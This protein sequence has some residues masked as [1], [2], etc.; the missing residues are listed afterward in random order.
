MNY[1]TSIQQAFHSS[2]MNVDE[3]M[4]YVNIRET[5]ENSV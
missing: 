4:K 3:R 2:S 1:L 5:A